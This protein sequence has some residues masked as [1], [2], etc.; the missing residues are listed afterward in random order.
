MDFLRRRL[1]LIFRSAIS[2]LFIWVVVRGANWANVWTHV[3]TM[4]LRW[5]AFSLVAF[6]PTILIVSWRWRLLMQVHDVFLR[7]WRVIELNMIS[8]F[9]SA[10]LVG[11]TGG[12][13]VKIFYVARAVPQK[14]AG[15][16]FTVVVDRV[17]GMVAML[18][19]GVA[20]SF[21]QLPL[22]NS[23]PYT[24]FFTGVF[25]LLAAGALVGSVGATFGPFLLRRP[26]LRALVGRLPFASRVTKVLAAY[27]I[28]ARAIGHNVVALLISVPSQA[29]IV[30]MGYC[31][32]RA[33]HLN[34]PLL[35]FCSILTMVNMLIALPISIAGLGVREQLFRTFL[36]LVGIDKDTAYT[37]S[38]T[39]FVLN[40]AWS[41]LG[42]AFYHLYRHENHVPPPHVNEDHPILSQV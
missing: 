30:L 16:A 4:D 9:F 12:D 31:I 1:G 21:T 22:L 34:P 42:G 40:L 33:M 18:F 10:F 37:F 15:V 6:I 41:L 32:L 2:L 17:I 36:A 26:A 5:L 29:C 24:R 23:Q 11:T 3:R 14:K 25:Y 35:A 8:Q 13:V 19:F 38:I 28:T 27:E 7:Y 39:F 20:L